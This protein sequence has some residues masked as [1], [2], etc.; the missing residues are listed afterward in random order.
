V[1]SFV[2]IINYRNF[3]SCKF[4]FPIRLC[5]N[6]RKTVFERVIR[7]IRPSHE[8]DHIQKNLA[9]KKVSRERNCN[10]YGTSANNNISFSYKVTFQLHL[11]HIQCNI[12]LLCLR[13]MLLMMFN[14]SKDVTKST[15]KTGACR[16]RRGDTYKRA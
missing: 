15:A 5:S 10:A 6:E 9:L 13:N 1:G 14:L 8:V 12:L 3:V 4:V 11:L 2:L 7:E 16:K